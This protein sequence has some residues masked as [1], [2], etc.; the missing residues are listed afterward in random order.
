MII[1]IYMAHINIEFKARCPDPDRIRQILT[2]KNADFKGVDHQIDTYFNVEKGRLK[3][4]QGNIEN[5]LIYYE[6]EDVAGAKRS[7]VVLHPVQG[8]DSLKKILSRSYGVLAVVDKEREI[9]FIENVK[10]HIDQVKGLGSFVEVEAIDNEG[11]IDPVFLKEQCDAYQ[12]LFQ[13]GV[14]DM[15]AIS[16]SDMILQQV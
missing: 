10:F 14:D 7:D 11:A 2:S 3:L 6:R 16:Y 9:Y 15:L 1:K 13:I 8:G 5:H 4:R 12:D